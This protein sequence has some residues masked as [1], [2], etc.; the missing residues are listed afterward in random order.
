[1][2]KKLQ[3]F[4]SSTYTDLIEERQIAVESVLN[5][6]HI[7]AGMELFKSADKTQKEIIKRWIDESDVYM[8][9]LGGRYG[10]IDPESNLSYTHW[11]YNYAGEIGKPRFAVVIDNEYLES[12]VKEVGV[13]V[14]E[15]TNITKYDV[16]ILDV[17]SKICKFYSD[18]KDIKI[19]V[20]ESLKE[21]ERDENLSGW[22]SGQELSTHKGL[23]ESYVNLLEENRKLQEENNKLKEKER[24][25]NEILGVPYKEIKDVFENNT[26]II[27]ADVDGE[28]SNEERKV[29]LHLLFTVTAD[30][31]SIGIDNRMGMSN[32]DNV[33]FFKLA[34]KLMEFGLIE[35][36]KLTGSTAQRVQTSKDGLRYLKFAEL[37]KN[38]MKVEN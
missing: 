25:E 23:E 19:T 7:P 29:N 10:S 27:P 34:P 31:F 36:T 35:K 2:R 17:L 3:V 28:G 33:L 13:S 11:E 37:E 38:K 20:L 24:K 22:V 15:R 14:L 4:I 1:M 5:A 16:F 26:V 12:R 18:L 8:L 32:L 21:Y 9:I 30:R 6:G